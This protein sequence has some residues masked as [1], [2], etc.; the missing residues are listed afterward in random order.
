LGMS[1][2]GYL[3]SD[4]IQVYYANSSYIKLRVTIQYRIRVDDY[5]D[6]YSGITINAPV[7]I[8]Y[9]KDGSGA[10]YYLN[11]DGIWQS[12]EYLIYI[13][14]IPP[15]LDF[16]TISWDVAIPSD[17]VLQIRLGQSQTVYSSYNIIYK[18]VVLQWIKLQDESF[19]LLPDSITKSQ[20]VISNNIYNHPEVSLRLFDAPITT[21]PSYDEIYG[22]SYW[23]TLFWKDGSDY[24][25]TKNWKEASESSYQRIQ[26]RLLRDIVNQYQYATTILSGTIKGDGISFNSIIIEPKYDSKWYMINRAAYNTKF[27]EWFVELVEIRRISYEYLD[28][29]L[30]EHILD[31]NGDP[32]AVFY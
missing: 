24:V 21:D 31:E 16:L 6:D 11:S 25:P 13:R 3:Q 30:G 28:D 2:G 9:T 19:D 5:A 27:D 14:K 1:K 18:S 7:R 26:D 29:E 20:G 10:V 32:I 17:G 22:N 8:K 23:G 15:S 4:N 12:S